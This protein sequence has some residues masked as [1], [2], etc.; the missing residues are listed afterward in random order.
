MWVLRCRRRRVLLLVRAFVNGCVTATGY[1]P[2]LLPCQLLLWLHLQL[3]LTSDDVPPSHTMH[4]Q[5]CCVL[6]TH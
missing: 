1:T 6:C 3:L 5:R 4:P 2:E